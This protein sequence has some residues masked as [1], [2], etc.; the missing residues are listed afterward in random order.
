MLGWWLSCQ[1]IRRHV[2]RAQHRS[3]FY[4][5]NTLHIIMNIGGRLKCLSDAIHRCAS[6]STLIWVTV[7]HLYGAKLLPKS[8]LI[9]SFIPERTQFSE[10]W[11]KINLFLFKKMPSTIR[12]PNCSVVEGQGQN[13]TTVQHEACLIEHPKIYITVTSLW[14]R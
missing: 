13:Q 4:K 14:A 5:C 8:L 10:H 9:L 7:C 2:S 11:I 1:P 3:V 12:W 6:G